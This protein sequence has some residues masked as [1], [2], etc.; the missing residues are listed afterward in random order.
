ML[1]MACMS[2]DN[3]WIDTVLSADNNINT[4]IS[5]FN[6]IVTDNIKQYVPIKTFRIRK[7]L[8]KDIY[9]YEI[10]NCIVVN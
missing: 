5:N 6:I 1:S 7:L 2:R 9:R 8:P 4:F 10:Y 3:D